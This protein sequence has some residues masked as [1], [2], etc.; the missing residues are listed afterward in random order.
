M[1][2][3]IFI[4]LNTDTTLVN[5]GESLQTDE[6]MVTEQFTESL[7]K[8]VIEE[9]LGNVYTKSSDFLNVQH[10]TLTD[11]S[12]HYDSYINDYS[13]DNT[14]I[15]DDSQLE[16]SVQYDIS[17]QNIDSDVV[18]K[19]GGLSQNEFSNNNDYQ[20]TEEMLMSERE[21]EK[22]TKKELEEEEREKM[23]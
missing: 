23:Q 12:D 10:D 6:R 20:T 13:F 4:S 16:T 2:T 9:G 7:H 1:L 22:K 19:I 5:Y 21:R 17:E 3:N 11:A 14:T 18:P 8:D 15:I